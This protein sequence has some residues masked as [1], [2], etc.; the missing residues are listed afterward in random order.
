VRVPAGSPG[1]AHRLAFG[2]EEVCRLVEEEKFALGGRRVERAI[3]DVA[4]GSGHSCVPVMAAPAAAA[5]GVSRGTQG[6][7]SDAGGAAC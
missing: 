3:R 1:F 4:V 5:T 7:I 6:S 2:D